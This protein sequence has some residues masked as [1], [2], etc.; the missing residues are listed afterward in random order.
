M[1]SLPLFRNFMEFVTVKYKKCQIGLFSGN[2]K[3]YLETEKKVL[4][5]WKKYFVDLFRKYPISFRDCAS[6]A[7]NKF[8]TL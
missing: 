8:I 3:N 4:I 2:I 7:K 5:C 1:S 6:N